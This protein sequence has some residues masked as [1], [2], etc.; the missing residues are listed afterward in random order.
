MHDSLPLSRRHE[1]A[2]RLRQGQPVSSGEL[3]REFGVSEDAIR[4]DLRALAAEGLCER[5]YGGALPLS[6]AGAPLASRAEE[7]PAAK[8]ALAARAAEL[9]QPGQTIFLDCG[10]TTA[11]LASHLAAHLPQGSGLRVVTNS[12]P[13]ATAL[14]SRQ[15][16]S[17][18]LLGGAVDPS[19]GGCVDGRALA[20]LPR[21]A[22]DLCLLGACALSPDGTLAGFDRAD[23]DMKQALLTASGATALM[24][25][26]DKLGTRAPFP[27]G[28][29]RAL[30]HLI[31]EHD[32]PAEQLA[33]LASTGAP[34]PL[35]AAPPRS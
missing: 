8:A 16:I 3:A 33:A 31:L 13:A 26:S 25:T 23:S 32:A 2:G 22:I 27:F 20:E 35:R 11:R 15:D 19:I 9:V 14:S 29:A 10:S 21:Y 7:Q 6:P 18:F 28:A 1:I 34:D 24:M 4:R 17:L 30:T 5:V 12:L